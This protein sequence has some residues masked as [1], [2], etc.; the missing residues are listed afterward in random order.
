ME[1]CGGQ[2]RSVGVHGGPWGSGVGGA[3]R[4]SA[5]VGK[6][7]WGSVHVG[8]GSV[9][10]RGGRWRPVGVGGG[11]WGSVVVGGS[12]G[13]VGGGGVVVGRGQCDGTRLLC[14]IVH[15]RI[16]LHNFDN[17]TRFFYKFT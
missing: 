7:R 17:C 6:G 10:A 9:E 11:R 8:G 5:G 4:V 1:V 3:Q 13:V 16:F 14:T 15:V 2:W 12:G